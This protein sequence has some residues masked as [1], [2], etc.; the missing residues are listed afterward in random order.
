MEASRSQP[1]SPL[2]TRAHFSAGSASRGLVLDGRFW[3][4]L[5]IL[6]TV[7]GSPQD[8]GYPF[9]S[10]LSEVQQM[11]GNTLERQVGEFLM[12]VRVHG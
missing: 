1:D 5:I 6:R 9:L 10:P 12:I 3:N 7:E 4:Q 8:G 2:N 11:A